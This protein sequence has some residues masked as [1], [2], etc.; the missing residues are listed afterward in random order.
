MDHETPRPPR[1]SPLAPVAAVVTTLLCGCAHLSR[2]NSSA[3]APAATPAQPVSL[4]DGKMVVL[5]PAAADDQNADRQPLAV[6]FAQ[7][8]HKLRPDL[9]ATP[10]DSALSAIN[11]AGLTD[12]YAQLYTTYRNTGGFDSHA[13]Q[14]IAQATGGRYLVQ[15]R[16]ESLKNSQGTGPLALVGV[17]RKETLDAHVVAQIWDGTDGQLLWQAASEDRRTKRSLFVPRS[18]QFSD[19]AGPATEQLVKQLPH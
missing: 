11:A 9:E 5:M 6:A 13:L 15:L 8:L 19:V 3:N 16:L 4:S 10:L 7:S 18:V 14:Q 1:C 2:D 12:S 17:K